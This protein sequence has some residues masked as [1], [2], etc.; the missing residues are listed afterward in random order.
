M[1][2]HLHSEEPT[3]LPAELPAKANGLS[4]IPLI[5]MSG[6]WLGPVLMFWMYVWGLRR[7]HAYPAGDLAPPA[8][9]FVLVLTA[10]FA[11]AWV[12]RAY[13][14]IATFER[15]GRIY[16]LLGIKLFRKI[17][18]DGDLANRWRRRSEPAQKMIHHRAH[19]A[20]FVQRTEQSEKGH[21]VLLALG[22]YSAAHA[23]AIGWW[24]W[25]IF[26]SV[27]NVLVNLYPIMLQ[28][29]TRSR[30]TRLL[31]RERGAARATRTVV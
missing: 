31:A 6:G 28:R 15:S 19:A 5:L 18:P 16:E 24:G 21:L 7:P 1:S 20:A 4:A 30:I 14:R 29:Y 2:E 23:A 10:C 8:L 11:L 3:P 27:G 9:A 17:V 25:T 13:Y 12:P 26:I 22:L